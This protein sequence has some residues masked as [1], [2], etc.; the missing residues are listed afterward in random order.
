MHTDKN[1]LWNAGVENKRRDA[2]NA[3]GR[4]E[5]V[6]SALLCVLAFFSC[7]KIRVHLWLKNKKPTAIWQWVLVKS[8]L[9][10]KNP[11][12]RRKTAASRL[13]G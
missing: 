4:K 6:S 7:H 11:P 1:V 2:E 5:N 8:L 3:E 10:I 13:A 9:R 12:P